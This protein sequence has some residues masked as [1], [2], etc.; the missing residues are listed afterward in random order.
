MDSTN[1]E[2]AHE[3]PPMIRIYKDGRVE[4]L[5]GTETVPPSFDPKTNV[6]SKD[7]VY[8]PENNLSVRLYLPKN[9]HQ[10]QKLPILVYFHGGGFC[11]E[12]AFSPTYHCYLNS[13]VSGANIIAVS[14]DYRRAPEHCLPAAYNDSWTA[15]K[16]VASHFDQKGPEDWLNH[17]AN[18]DRVFLYGDS[19]GANIAHRMAMKHGHEEKLDVVNV[20]GIILCHPYFCGH[21]IIAGE[22]SGSRNR[23]FAGKLWQIVCPSSS[24]VDDPWIDPT[25]DPNLGG[26][27]CSRVQ[28]I[29]SEKDFLRGR[30]WYYA[31]KLRGSGWSGD[32]EVIDFKGEDH[33][34]HLFKPTCDKAVAMMKKVVSFINL[35]G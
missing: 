5:L 26:L 6:E 16:W 21:E 10:N 7:V 3:I 19:A 4:R 13:L 9:T 17:H 32:L 22:T 1:S 28:V 24:G 8:S 34:F 20:E 29:V 30:G 23:E 15:L 33:V 27:G 11:I 2:V 12:T 31:E 18:F 35:E 14:V 25:K